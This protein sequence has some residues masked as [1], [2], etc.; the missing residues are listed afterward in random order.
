MTTE[1]LST[2]RIREI[3][4]EL[5]V[6]VAVFFITMV[7]TGVISFVPTL[8]YS[9]SKTP[10]IPLA[11]GET[12][13]IFTGAIL[14]LRLLSL[15]AWPRIR[16][17]GQ[18]VPRLLRDITTFLVWYSAACAIASYAFGQSLTQLIAASTVALGIMGFAL[19][20]PILDAFSGIVLA[21][22]R[23]FGMGDWVGVSN[24]TVPFGRVVE[25]NWRAV[26]LQTPN[27]VVHVIP[28]SLFTGNDT[29]LYSRPEA[30]FRDEIT[31]TLPFNVTTHQGQRI[32]LGAANQVEEVGTL[33][34]KSIVTISEYNDRGVVWKLLYWCPS[35]MRVPPVRF[36]IHQN[37]LKNLKYAGIDI[38]VSSMNIRRTVEAEDIFR[39]IQGVEPLI[40]R[41]SLFATLTVDELRYL[42]SHSVSRLAIAGAALL[43][44]GESGDSLFV[45]CEGLLEVSKG[46]AHGTKVVGRIHPGQFFGERTFLLGEPRSATVVPVIDAIVMEI[47]KGA[48]TQLLQARPELTTHLAEVLAERHALTDAKLNATPDSASNAQ[49]LMDKMVDR[50][51]VFFEIKKSQAK[52]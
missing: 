33:P 10:P 17:Q 38:P 21:L 31:V 48:M 7:L 25:M 27:E 15:F 46:G 18:P 50:I 47:T 19:Q 20:R 49:T 26:H 36:L 39:Q 34:R 28:N 43:T 32:L 2:A 22:Q 35:P 8:D 6:P 41:L 29:K 9:G 40:Q 16:L 24:D 30:F 14:A 37:I 52:K 5:L 1:Q 51:S 12:I 45:L 4:R 23:P 13:L 11:F 3:V 42:S 44:E